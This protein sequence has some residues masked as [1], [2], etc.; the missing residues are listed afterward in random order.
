MVL[1]LFRILKYIFLIQTIQT[2][3]KKEMYGSIIL[4]GLNVYIIH[5]SKIVGIHTPKLWTFRLVSIE[6][7]YNNPKLYW[8]LIIHKGFGPRRGIEEGLKKKK[9]K[10]KTN[11]ILVLT[12]IRVGLIFLCIGIILNVQQYVYFLYINLF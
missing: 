9:L 1:A 10:Y 2:K 12:W 6:M 3:I 5:I 4:V 8:F 7:T 11:L